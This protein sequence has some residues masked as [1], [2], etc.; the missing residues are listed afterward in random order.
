MLERL[1]GGDPPRRI[2]V[3]HP[4]DKVAEQRVYKVLLPKRL[5]GARRIEAPC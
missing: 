5:S 1:K 2:Q 3:C 4:A